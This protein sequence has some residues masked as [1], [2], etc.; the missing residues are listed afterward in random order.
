MSCFLVGVGTVVLLE[1]AAVYVL[2]R[3]WLRD[4]EPRR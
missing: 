3:L 1:V 4:V 2:Y